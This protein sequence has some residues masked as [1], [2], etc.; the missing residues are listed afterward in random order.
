MEIS[1]INTG[2]PIAFTS[3]ES[4]RDLLANK[5][6]ELHEQDNLFDYPFDILSFD[7]I[8]IETNIAEGMIFKSRQTGIIHN[9]TMDVD[10]CYKYI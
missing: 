9:F 1:S 8:F 7:N 3:D 6:V 10:P 2:T 5:P 4:M